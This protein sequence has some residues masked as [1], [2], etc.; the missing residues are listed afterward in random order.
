[1]QFSFKPQW[2][3]DPAQQRR[4]MPS[5]LIALMLFSFIG[6]TSCASY[7]QED[8]VSTDN[9]PTDIV[10]K[11]TC[12]DPKAPFTGTLAV[13]GVVSQVSG[14]GNGT[15]HAAG[16]GMNCTFKKVNADGDINLE[17]TQAGLSLGSTHNDSPYGGV[18]VK[19]F[20]S[21]K[22]DYTYFCTAK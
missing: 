19:I 22:L 18:Q 11:V 1:M 2:L 3:F 15:F 7:N 4:F 14:T 10:M 17:V 21:N 6:L 5:I 20:R 8:T 9:P 12:S 16:H 13:D